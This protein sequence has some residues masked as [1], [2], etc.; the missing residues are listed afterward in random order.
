MHGR[1]GVGESIDEQ[2]SPDNANMASQA[3]PTSGA[4]HLTGI[5]PP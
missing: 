1:T 5:C 4:V 3:S 2:F